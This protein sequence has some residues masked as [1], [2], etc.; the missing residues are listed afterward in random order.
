[1]NPRPGGIERSRAPGPLRLLPTHRRRSARLFAV[2]GEWFDAGRNRR[3]TGVS[4]EAARLCAG[5]I[6]KLRAGLLEVV[7]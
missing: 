4:F 1:M 6:A 7:A 2:R 3:A 5:A